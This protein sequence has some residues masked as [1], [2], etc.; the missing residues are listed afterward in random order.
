MIT[1]FIE[2]YIA[3]R[4]RT[5]TRDTRTTYD[6]ETTRIADIMYEYDDRIDVIDVFRRRDDQRIYVCMRIDDHEHMFIYVS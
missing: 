2:R 6:D 3:R 4:H 5:F 1:Q